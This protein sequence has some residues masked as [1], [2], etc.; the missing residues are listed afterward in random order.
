M[1]CFVVMVTPKKL[2]TWR[3]GDKTKTERTL[4][5]GMKVV[6][7]GESLVHRNES[8][9]REVSEGTGMI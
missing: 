2:I 1:K 7:R 3:R 9:A 4:V 6:V 8:C 5:R